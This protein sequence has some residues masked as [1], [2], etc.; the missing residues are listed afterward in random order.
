M[1]FNTNSSYPQRRFDPNL[2]SI[3]WYQYA[4]FAGNSRVFSRVI[5]GSFRGYF[6][7]LLHNHGKLRLLALYDRYFE[8]HKTKFWERNNSVSVKIRREKKTRNSA[9]II[10]ANPGISARKKTLEFTVSILKIQS[11]LVKY[12]TVYQYEHTVSILKNQSKLG[13]Y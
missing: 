10:P 12:S 8:S 13:K 5:R 2:V 11:K 3:E 7:V 4:E 9:G 6:A 1:V